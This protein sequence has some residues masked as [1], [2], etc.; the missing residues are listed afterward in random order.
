[1][2][3]TIGTI[4]IVRIRIAANMLEPTVGSVLKIGRKP[5]VPCSAGPSVFDDERAE[6]EDSPEAEHDAREW[7]PACRR[8][9]RRHRTDAARRELAQEER[10]RDRDRRCE[11]QGAERRDDGAEDE[12]R[13][14][15]ELLVRV[16]RLCRQ[17]AEAELL[18]RRPRFG[19]ELTRD[20][21]EQ[22]DAAERSQ[23]RDDVED[24]VPEAEAA[25]PPK[26]GG[27]GG[28]FRRECHSRRRAYEWT[29]FRVALPRATT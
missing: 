21:P 15:E 24:R 23:Q 20:Q 19:E 3:E 29:F 12:R 27:A 1:M 18:H 6:H 14:A 9:R 22:H 7:R 26:G 8:G 5:S 11:Q 16:P 17:E 13:S 28:R 4:M 10:D 2:L 25:P